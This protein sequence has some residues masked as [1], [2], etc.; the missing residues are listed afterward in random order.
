MDPKF[1]SS[2]IPKKP[3]PVKSTG[4]VRQH[5]SF[6]LV[7]FLSTIAFIAVLGLSAAA[8]VYERIIEDRV[9]QKGA[10]LAAEKDKLDLSN[11]DEYKRLADRL[12][13]AK[14]LIASHRALSKVFFSLNEETLHNVEY[15]SFQLVDPLSGENPELSIVGRAASFNALTVQSDVF[16]RSPAIKDFV[17]SDI[18]TDEAGRI[19]FGLEVTLLGDEFLFGE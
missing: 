15:S 9:N 11:L 19:L 6:N 4:K 1:R 18:K 17:F 16:K 14:S 10:E 3:L 12:K 13:E 7:V 2:F 5:H 8:F